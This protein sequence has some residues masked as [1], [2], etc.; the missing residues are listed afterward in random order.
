MRKVAMRDIEK[1]NVD[2][3]EYKVMNGK[4]VKVGR[5]HRRN[6]LTLY[7]YMIFFAVVITVTVL[8]VTLLFNANEVVVSGTQLYSSEQIRMICGVETG[9]NLIRLDTHTAEQCV[10]ESLSYVDDIKVLR[11][12]PGRISIKVTE[13]VPK[14]NIE[15]DGRYY[16]VSESGKILEAGLDKPM[17]GLIVIVGYD[18]KDMKVGDKV[19]SND[20]MKQNI[21]D[22]IFASLEHTGLKE[23]I[24]AINITDRSNIKLNYDSRINILLGSSLDLEYKLSAVK[25]IID[26]KISDTF[27]GVIYYHTD[28][29]G[30]SVIDSDKLSGSLKNEAPADYTVHENGEEGD[31]PLQDKYNSG[32]K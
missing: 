24:S 31:V 10:L 16:V 3:S 9:D 29:G 1:Q 15:Q 27:N 21:T 13:A 22:T 4:R 20:D 26:T 25:V 11:S 6:N 23:H 18:L 14:A 7:Y 32:L 5:R 17:G 30:V 19:E 28:S 2:R 12:F 8:S